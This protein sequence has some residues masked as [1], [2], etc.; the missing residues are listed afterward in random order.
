MPWRDKHNLGAE[1]VCEVHDLLRINDAYLLE[2]DLGFTYWAG[3]FATTVRTDEGLFRQG[4][5]TYHLTAHTE[6]L[7]G[8]GH[9]RELA[10]ALEHE[11]DQCSLSAPFYHQDSD[12]FN[13]HCGVYAGDENISWIR[14]TFAAAVALQVAEAHDMG[15]RLA[16]Q[17]N[18]VP[19]ASGHPKTG[20]RTHA[21]D[22]LTHAYSFFTG[23]GQQPSRWSSHEEWKESSWVMEREADRF[24]L[25][26]GTSL[27]GWFPWHCGEHEMVVTVRTDEPHP[28]LGN[29]LHITLTIP[30]QLTA[31][32]I[33]YLALELNTMERTT[34]KRCHMLGSWCEH[35]GMLAFRTF[36]P[37]AL[38]EPRLLHDMIVNFATRALWAD[39]FFVAKREAASHPGQPCQ[40]SLG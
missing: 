1:I 25:D 4:T 13:L 23:S 14:K 31:E 29:G 30:M 3:D 24:E 6:F 20:L 8:R 9:M 32:G 39:E 7:K 36:I 12:T 26:S 27:T 21:D 19:A 37:N 15:H 11:M 40:A 22:I 10:L 5:V 28:R 38:Y 18:T 35:D 33:G 16:R 17:L 34:Y 2:S